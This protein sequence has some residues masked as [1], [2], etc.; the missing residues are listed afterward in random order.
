MFGLKRLQSLHVQITS[1]LLHCG[2]I[3]RQRIAYRLQLT[4]V[5]I[6]F[7]IKWDAYNYSLDQC[8]FEL[9]KYSKVLDRDAVNY[10]YVCL[11][12]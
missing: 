2:S 5:R 1:C 7:E 6:L 12:V 8:N 3:W 9:L 11:F 4:E 10:L